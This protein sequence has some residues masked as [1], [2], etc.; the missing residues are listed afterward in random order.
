M[1]LVI[2]MMVAT[3]LLIALTAVLPSV[4]QEGQREREAELSSEEPSTA[5]PWR[6]FTASLAAT[7]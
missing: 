2:V 7:P 4:Y 6:Y 1:V 5:E 3:L